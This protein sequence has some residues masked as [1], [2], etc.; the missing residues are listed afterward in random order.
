MP[1]KDFSATIDILK[2]LL[3]DIKTIR[4]PIEQDRGRPPWYGKWI[5]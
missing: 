1:A 3:S 2:A 4:I 5:I